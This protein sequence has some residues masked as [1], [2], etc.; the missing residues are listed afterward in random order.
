[1]MLKHSEVLAHVWK[2]HLD[3]NPY[4]H[5]TTVIILEPCAAR[6]QIYA[7]ISAI[8][9]LVSR[10]DSVTVV[11]YVAG[12]F[13]CERMRENFEKFNI[14]MFRNRI[15]RHP[16]TGAAKQNDG[17]SVWKEGAIDDYLVPRPDIGLP[18]S[19]IWFCEFENCKSLMADANKARKYDMIFHD[20]Y[21]EH[22]CRMLGDEARK[23]RGNVGGLGLLGR[24]GFFR[25]LK[26]KQEW[27]EQRDQRWAKTAKDALSSKRDTMIALMTEMPTTSDILDDFG[28]P[29][30][31][32]VAVN[33]SVGLELERESSSSSDDVDEVLNGDLWASDQGR[34]A[35]MSSKEF[36]E[37]VHGVQRKME[38]KD[39]LDKILEGK[40]KK[41]FN[42]AVDADA[43]KTL[44]PEEMA[45]FAKVEKVRIRR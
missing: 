33:A 37:E 18:K 32:V 34:R 43:K 22:H 13:F 35:G 7:E 11:E 23:T 17:K 1:M 44:S 15:E 16:A 14:S 4:E 36:L 39:R 25:G 26:D 42:D 6:A 24:K 12:R 30:T 40:A 31:T 41:D 2:P 5:P 20:C 9:Q 45:S 38:E 28:I 21:D 27:L 8:R 10:I 19:Q 3:P 29:P